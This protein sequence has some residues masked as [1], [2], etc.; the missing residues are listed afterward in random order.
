MSHAVQLVK[1]GGPDTG[2]TT[3]TCRDC[4][5]SS[6]AYSR[7]T[8]EG[9]ELAER[10]AAR[11]MAA[12]TFTPGPAA[13]PPFT[14]ITTDLKVG[15]LVQLDP[16]NADG[17]QLESYFITE[18][19]MVDIMSNPPRI[20]VLVHVDGDPATKHLLFADELKPAVV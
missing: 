9:R 20:R 16:L 7:R 6:P 19:F 2:Y 13:K 14:T 8:I 3:A 12:H 11:H 4:G 18:R 1:T 17:K 10:D 5:W 15:D